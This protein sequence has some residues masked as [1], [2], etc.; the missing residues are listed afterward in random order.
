MTQLTSAV[1]ADLTA[2]LA[3]ATTQ[4]SETSAL[5]ATLEASPDVSALEAEIQR[6]VDLVAAR[7]ET[8]IQ[9]DQTI[10]QRESTIASLNDQVS[11]LLLG[12]EALNGIVAQRDLTIVARDQTIAAA[13]AAQVSVAL[14][15]LELAAALGVGA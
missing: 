7:D 10:A 2:R 9:R 5:V 8:I 1:L 4:L 11:N 12:T 6:L 3:L 15:S 14:A 13:S